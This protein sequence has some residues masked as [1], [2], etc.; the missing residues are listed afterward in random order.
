MGI[1]REKDVR[2]PREVD[3][4]VSLLKLNIQRSFQKGTEKRLFTKCVKLISVI[5]LYE[6]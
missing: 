6:V 2:I 1:P 3:L 4:E 5:I